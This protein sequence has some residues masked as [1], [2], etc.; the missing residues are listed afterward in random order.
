MVKGNK[1]YEY[2][3]NCQN[4]GNGCHNTKNRVIEKMCE[5]DNAKCKKMGTFLKCLLVC[6][7]LCCYIGTCCCEMEEISGPCMNELHSKCDKLIGCCKDLQSCLPD[8]MCEYLNCGTLMD[9]CHICK[10][11]SHNKNSKLSKKKSKQSKQSKKSK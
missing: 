4:L 1:V 9:Y 7:C 3:S 5:V 11:G 8:D 10:G 2:K 6:E